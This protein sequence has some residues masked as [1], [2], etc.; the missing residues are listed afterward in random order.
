ML[1]ALISNTYAAT[2]TKKD[3][4]A[5][6]EFHILTAVHAADAF[7]NRITGEEALRLNRLDANILPQYGKDYF[8][9]EANNNLLVEYFKALQSGV[10]PL[11]LM[12]TRN[13]IEIGCKR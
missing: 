11:A 5:F 13:D 4:E 7:S 1:M 8:L 9:G 10:K 2:V 12:L 3:C 6:R